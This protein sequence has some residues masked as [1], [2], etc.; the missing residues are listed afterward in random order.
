M[1]REPCKHAHTLHSHHSITTKSCAITSL[2]L[3]AMECFG[4]LAVEERSP[5]G[6]PL[7]DEE[8]T[9]L[10]TFERLQLV[11]GAGTDQGD[12]TL[13]ITEW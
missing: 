13:Y 3:L 5:A 12:G 4:L 6:G 10:Q 1:S 7:L 11:I 2:S 9:V 8:E